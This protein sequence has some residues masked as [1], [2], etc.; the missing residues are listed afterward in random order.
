MPRAKRPKPQR[1]KD[2]P[3]RVECPLCGFDIIHI[4]SPTSMRCMKCQHL[5]RPWAF[6]AKEMLDRWVESWRG[7]GPREVQGGYMVKHK[8]GER[9]KRPIK[10]DIKLDK[11]R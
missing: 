4:L 1:L 5:D 2:L 9:R 11:P 8:A 3:H 7:Y 6:G 10:P